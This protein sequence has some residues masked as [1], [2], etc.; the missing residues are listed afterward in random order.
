MFKEQEIKFFSGT[1]RVISPEETIK[2]NEEKLKI[3]GIT[4]IT[5]ITHLDRIGIPVFSA[6]RPTSQDGSVHY[7]AKEEMCQRKKV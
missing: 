4:R 6:I 1:H 7:D 5:E 2:T 3:A